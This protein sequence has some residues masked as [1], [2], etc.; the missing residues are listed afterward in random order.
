LLTETPT[1]WATDGQAALAALDAGKDLWSSEVINNDDDDEPSYTVDV[2]FDDVFAGSF[3]AAIDA[4]TTALQAADIPGAGDIY[5]EDRELIVVSASNPGTAADQRAI[6][7]VV[8][9]ALRA[10]LKTFGP[11]RDE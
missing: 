11:A 3:S 7:A 4:V 8:D 2:G 9:Q 1:H 6:D 10:A 5:R